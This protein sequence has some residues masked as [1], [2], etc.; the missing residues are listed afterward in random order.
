MGYLKPEGEYRTLSLTSKAVQALKNR[1]PIM[2]QLQEAEARPSNARARQT[3]LEYNHALFALVRQKRKELADAA[4]VPPYVI[5]SD[6]TLVEMCAYYPQS[7][8]NLL[9]ISGVGQVK[10]NQYGEVFLDVIKAYCQKKGLKEKPKEASRPKNDSGRRYV[11]VGE[12]YNAGESIQ[13][14]MERYQ[15]QASTIVN[16]LVRF[17]AAGNSLRNGGELQALTSTSPEQQQAAMGA[18]DEL[19]TAFLKPVFDKLE[20]EIDYD[21]LKILRLIYLSAQDQ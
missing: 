11:F 15:V 5:F 17:A 20:G 1:T 3:E 4:G 21:E 16:H 18:F 19:G 9:N 14:L 7:L 13:S 2:G 6:K 10:L 8:E 12:A